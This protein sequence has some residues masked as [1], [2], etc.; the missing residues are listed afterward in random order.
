M[1]T[2]KLDP[3][4][5]VLD[6][7]NSEQTTEPQTLTEAMGRVVHTETGAFPTTPS[8]TR[9][10]HQRMRDARAEIPRQIKKQPPMMKYKVDN[11]DSIVESVEPVL[12][13]HGIVVY[14]TTL[15]MVPDTIEL[16]KKNKQGEEYNEIVSRCIV[17]TLTTFAN[18]DNPED[19][20]ESINWGFGD[21]NDDKGP[22]KGSTYGAKSGLKKGLGLASGDDPDQEHG[23]HAPKRKPHPNAEQTQPV[24]MTVVT[25]A[26]LISDI[27]KL[28]DGGQEEVKEWIRSKGSDFQ[29]ISE[30]PDKLLDDCLLHFTDTV[31]E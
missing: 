5:G 28:A 22:G 4:E 26:Q 23:E 7:E 6:F 17:K 20:I 25:K 11:Y 14:H 12:L 2:S 9:N 27:A 24:G 13:K 19:K 8:D 15:E 10:I 1:A 18:I 30:I 29:A 3:E 21:G 16:T 31:K